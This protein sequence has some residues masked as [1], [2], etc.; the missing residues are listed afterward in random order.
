MEDKE[1]VDGFDFRLW[2]N[3]Q[4]CPLV[5]GGRVKSPSKGGGGR[6]KEIEVAFLNSPRNPF[7]Y[8]L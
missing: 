5:R 7:P 3:H 4:A 2:V 6:N 1:E 8:H